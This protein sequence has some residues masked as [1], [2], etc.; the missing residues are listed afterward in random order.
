MADNFSDKVVK[1]LQK[2]NLAVDLTEEVASKEVAAQSQDFRTMGAND[3]TAFAPGSAG[4]T[5]T[6]A[7]YKDIIITPGPG[8]GSQNQNTASQINFYTHSSA[9]SADTTGYDA[10]IRSTIYNYL[11]ADLTPALVIGGTDGTT[12]Y[13]PSAT[14]GGS[15]GLTVAKIWLHPF[16]G[17]IDA[18]TFDGNALILGQTANTASIQFGTNTGVSQSTTTRGHLG[19]TGTRLVIGDGTTANSIAYTSDIAG[20]QNIYSTFSDGTNSASPATTSDTFKFR[21]SNGVQVT[22][23]NNDPTHNDNLLISLSSVPNGALANSSVTIGSTTISLGGT[24]TTISGLT[25]VTSTTFTGNLVAGNIRINNTAGQIDTISGNLTIDSAGGTTSIADN[26]TV[27]GTTVS[28]TNATTTTLSAANATVTL[29]G[30][31][32]TISANSNKITNVA[33]PTA[34]ADAATKAYVDAVKTGLDVHASVRCVITAQIAGNYVQANPA[35]STSS[36]V[37]TITYTTTG[38]TVVDTTVTLAANDRVL[39]I[40]GIGGT[41]TANGVGITNGSDTEKFAANGIYTVQTAGTTGVATV[42]T[43]ALDTDDNLEL[44]GGTFTF[45]QEGQ[46]YEDT[47]WVCTTNTTSTPILFAPSTG[48]AGRI[49]FTQF[50]GAGKITVTAPLSKNVN[51]IS[52]SLK[53]NGGLTT[54]SNALA[55][56]LGASSITGTL[57][58]GDG[59]TGLTSFTDK[60]IFYANGTG[61]LGQSTGTSGQLLVANASG[62]PTFVTLGGDAASLSATGS[63]TL[64]NTAVT[65]GSYGSSTQV[66]TFS[67]DTKGRLTAAGNA[68][69]PTATSSVLGLASFGTAFTVTSGNVVLNT[70]GVGVGGTGSTS[71]TNNGINYVSSQTIVSGTALTWIPGN[72][73]S[74]GSSSTL[75]V[76]AAL[77]TSGTAMHLAAGAMTTGNALVINAGG[78]SFTAG[79]LIDAQNNSTSKFSVDYNGNLRATTKSFDIPHPTKEGMRLVYGVLEGPE[80]GVYHRGT[81]EGKD[82]LNV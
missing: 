72:T 71:Q 73:N 39:V 22:V 7:V 6:Q 25:S 5:I 62:V 50:T 9:V 67:V 66:A 41:V 47:G 79:K 65:G 2:Q 51:N 16:T 31:T 43:R 20:A 19:W 28:F 69:I 17:K 56:D 35:G 33:T 10:Q 8:G 76:N 44:E 63:L 52:L 82:K 49:Q 29:A 14:W 77:V 3:V 27:T 58:V 30:A 75:Y 40:G 12:K 59:G 37:A 18:N 13:A 32:S 74:S 70:V 1:K 11:E 54:E 64:A 57:A 36:G 45:V 23:T 61:A 21:G 55:V 48:T 81:V 68:A 4:G 15:S 42:L 34:D 60:G 80:H 26:L 46:I 38:A 78:G 53:A 24:A